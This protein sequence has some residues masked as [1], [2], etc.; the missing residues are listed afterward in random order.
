MSD[1]FVKVLDEIW[2]KARAEVRA[3]ARKAKAEARNEMV[4]IAKNLLVYGMTVREMADVT[5]LYIAVV[6]GLRNAM[7]AE[8]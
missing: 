4:E 8:S 1:E 2:E 6:A 3:E 5:G 7:C